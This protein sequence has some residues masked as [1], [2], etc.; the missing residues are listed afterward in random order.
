[1]IQTPILIVSF[2]PRSPLSGEK[3]CSARNHKGILNLG[4]SCTNAIKGN[5]IL[6][7][8]SI[9]ALPTLTVPSDS[10]C[11]PLGSHL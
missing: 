5:G 10:V 6:H 8:C 7:F 2:K 11:F 4:V 9:P 3:G 1:M